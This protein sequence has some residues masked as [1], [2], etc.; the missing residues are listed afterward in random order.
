MPV[1][2]YHAMRLPAVEGMV[3]SQRAAGARWP[4]RMETLVLG[5][6]MAALILNSG[7]SNAFIYFQF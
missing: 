4:D 1:L 5:S 6:M 2:V 7:T 3:R